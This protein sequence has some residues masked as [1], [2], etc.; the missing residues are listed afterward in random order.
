MLRSCW[1][2]QWHSELLTTLTAASCALP[3]GLDGNGCWHKSNL[4]TERYCER[5]WKQGA[6]K[7]VNKPL[8]AWCQEFLLALRLS[9]VAGTSSEAQ[10]VTLHLGKV[11]GDLQKIFKLW[12]KT[13]ANACI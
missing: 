9:A 6:R 13:W 12:S 11:S 4:L 7:L 10:H 3:S 8:D 1:E 2:Q 5:W